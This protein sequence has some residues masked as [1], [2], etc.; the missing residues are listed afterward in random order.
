MGKDFRDNIRGYNSAFAF[1]SIG[2]KLDK[3]LANGKEFNQ[4]VYSVTY[5]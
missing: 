5:Y 3:D 2:V 1:T 4:K